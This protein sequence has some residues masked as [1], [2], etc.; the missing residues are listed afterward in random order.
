[1]KFTNFVDQIVNAKR[2]WNRMNHLAALATPVKVRLSADIEVDRLIGKYVQSGLTKALDLGSGPSPRNPFC[3]S[4]CWGADIRSIGE[5]NVVYADISSGKLPFPD[6]TFDFVTAYDVL[7]HVPRFVRSEA[8]IQFP[9]ILL[10]NE[11]FRILKRNGHFFCIQPCYPAKEVFQDPTH[12]NVM[13]E[14][15]IPMYF[16]QNAWARI[17][18]YDGSFTVCEEGWLGFKYFALLTKSADLA[19][20]DMN[21][22][23]R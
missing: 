16:G 22:V 10:F 19:V 14:D 5:N 11:I 3:A 20:R 21:F 4:E 13:T 7:E 15:T 8:Q 23:Q 2:R 9:L 18:G 1:M 6:E 17:Y 12:V